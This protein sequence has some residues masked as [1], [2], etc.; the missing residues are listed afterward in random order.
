MPNTAQ[1]RAA[2]AV[3]DETGCF[4]ERSRELLAT[5]TPEGDFRRVNGGWTEQLGYEETE[6]A[7]RS[8]VEFVHPGDVEHTHAE[9]AKLRAGEMSVGFENHFRASDETYR[10]LRWTADIADG[11]V[12]VVARDVTKQRLRALSIADEQAYYLGLAEDSVRGFVAMDAELVIKDVNETMC[13]ML[14][15]SRAQMVG[16]KFGDLTVESWWGLGEM[17]RIIAAGFVTGYELTFQGTDGRLVPASC[18][19]GVFRDAAG[20]VAGVLAGVRTVGAKRALQGS[21]LA[22]A[23]YAR[24]L[25]ESSVEAMMTTDADGLITDVNRQ[26]E[27]L[28]ERGRD[29]LIGWPFRDYVTEPTRADQVILRTFREG[30]VINFELNVSGLDGHETAVSYNAATFADSAGTVQ[31]VVATARD[32]SDVKRLEH[33]LR[34]MTRELAERVAELEASNAE[35]QSFSYSVSHD[36]RAPLRAI[37]GFSRIVIE[38]EEGTLTDSQR[39]YLALVRDNT[40]FMGTLI[41]ELLAFSRLANQPLN[42]TTVH[43]DELVAALQTEICADQAGRIIEFTNGVLPAVQADPG[44]LRQV[45]ANLLANAVK[46]SRQRET[47]LITVASETRRGEL[48]FLVRDNGV[49]FDMRYRDRLFEA[50]QRLHRAEDY[51]GNGVGLAIVRRIVARHGGRAWARSQPDRGATFYFTLEDRAP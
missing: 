39:R 36:L 41:D 32:I 22:A 16:A 5:V 23:S 1:R 44:L 4:F 24:S 38:D 31:G 14:G 43:T 40:Q 10:W 17:R 50:F 19:F 8:L 42:R 37:D 45:F 29:A 27:L 7:G 34:E 51:E 47:T 20:D 30:R 6:L 9:L 48:I 11:V 49:G 25:I 26:M 18:N 21:L 2:T 15:R 13:E 46:Y 35:L 33:Q 12:Y 28:T 3:F